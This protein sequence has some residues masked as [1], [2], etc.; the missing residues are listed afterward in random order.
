ML[1][2]LLTV[3]S[4]ASAPEVA[5]LSSRGDTAELRFQPIGAA[6]LSP[7]VVRFTH[8]EGSP[9]QGSLLPASRVVIAS[10]VLPSGADVS[11]A[12]GLLRLESGKPARVLADQLVYGSKPLISAEGRVFVSRGRAGPVVAGEPRLDQLTIDEIDP[13]SAKARTVFSTRGFVA[14]LVGALGREVLVYEVNAFGAR[15]VAVHADTLGARTVLA[16]M[17]PMARD[18]VLDA[19]R[20]RVLFTQVDTSGDG[21]HVEEASLTDGST[22]VAASGPEVTLLPAVRADGRVLIS[23]GEG[24]GLINVDGSEGLPAQGPGFERVVLERKDLLIGLHERPSDFP[25][26]FVLKGSEA[27]QFV[28]PSDAR[29]CVAGVLP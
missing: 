22:R 1:L 23:R 17:V 4:L 29:L 13:S 16:S 15:L 3:V 26:I 11:F 18:F 10:A 20:K 14:F 28:T 21:W 24:L 12:S 5:V 8:A 9:V 25:S 2:S 7:A 6:A 27:L 19:P